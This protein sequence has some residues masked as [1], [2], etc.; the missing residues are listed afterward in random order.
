L[1]GV[2]I[3]TQPATSILAASIPQVSRG[4][5]K[6]TLATDHQSAGLVPISWR[7]LGKGDGAV[8][9]LIYAGA[10]SNRIFVDDTIEG[11]LAIRA[12]QFPGNMV[13]QFPFSGREFV[14]I[15]VLR[16]TVGFYTV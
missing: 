9:Q 6:F 4:V 1:D 12:V 15:S 5:A 7:I 3:R 10:P 11:Q 2:V 13:I 16:V 14:I 8:V